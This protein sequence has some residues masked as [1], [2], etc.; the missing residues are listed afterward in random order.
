[1]GSY[2]KNEIFNRTKIQK[3]KL[4]VIDFCSIFDANHWVVITKLRYSTEPKSQKYAGSYGFLS[5][6]KK[7]EINVA[8]N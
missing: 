3:K 2:Y 6:A 7:L 8:E 4:K 1:M 5:F